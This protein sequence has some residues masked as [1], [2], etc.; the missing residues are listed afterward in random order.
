M[1]WCS[2]NFSQTSAAEAEVGYELSPMTWLEYLETSATPNGYD[3]GVDTLVSSFPLQ[4]CPWADFTSQGG[5]QKFT[6]QGA[7]ISNLTISSTCNNGPTTTLKFYVSD[8]PVTLGTELISAKSLKFDVVMTNYPYKDQTNSSYVALEVRARG[9]S[10][11]EVRT[12]GNN[13]SGSKDGFLELESSDNSTAWFKW[14][15][16]LEQPAG[17]AVVVKNFAPFSGYSDVTTGETDNRAF[18]SFA[19]VQPAVVE[20][21]PIT[22]VTG[23]SSAV[24]TVVAFGLLLA[25]LVAVLAL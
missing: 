25:V 2:P 5:F 17:A 1:I 3:A 20:W 4:N 10:E 21:D 8:K 18:L 15:S 14:K 24:S 13:T 19:A 22:G 12:S 9:K 7:E 23:T 11:L 6:S 16:T